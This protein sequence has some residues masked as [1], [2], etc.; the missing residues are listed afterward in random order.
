M[1]GKATKKAS[2]PTPYEFEK[3]ADVETTDEVEKAF[4][5]LKSK[6]LAMKY[7]PGSSFSFDEEIAIFEE[8]LK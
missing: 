3:Y 5:S 4:K 7:Q 1:S 2:E 6:L 8:F